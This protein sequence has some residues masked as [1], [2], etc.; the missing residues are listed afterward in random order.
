MLGK[1]ASILAAYIRAA[2]LDML[3]KGQELDKGRL[4]WAG[5]ALSRYPVEVVWRGCLE[6]MKRY[7]GHIWPTINI[8]FRDIYNAVGKTEGFCKALQGVVYKYLNIPEEEWPEDVLSYYR[9]L[10]EVAGV[11]P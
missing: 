5:E 9:L 10:V 6:A 1:V 7:F 3:R 11:D 8:Y 4:I 2:G